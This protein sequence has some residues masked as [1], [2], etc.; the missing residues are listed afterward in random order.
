MMK[1]IIELGRKEYNLYHINFFRSNF[2]HTLFDDFQKINV[3][4]CD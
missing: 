2:F 1:L 4:S 3:I